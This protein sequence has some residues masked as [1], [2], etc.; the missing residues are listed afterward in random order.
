MGGEGLNKGSTFYWKS[1][2]DWTLQFISAI[3]IHITTSLQLVFIRPQIL[4]PV[5]SSGFVFLKKR[6]CQ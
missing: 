2:A 6:C 1:V 5:K 3:S 4:H